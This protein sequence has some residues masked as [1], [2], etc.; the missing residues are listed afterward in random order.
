M[1][2]GVYYGTAGVVCCGSVMEYRLLGT[3]IDGVG[4]ESPFT[5]MIDST[6]RTAGQANS[7][8]LRRFTIHVVL[9]TFVGASVYLLFRTRSLLVFHWVEAI[10]LQ[11]HL[12]V[13]RDAVSDVQ[14]PQWLL[15]SLPDG[16]WVYATTSWMVL[17]WREPRSWLWLSTGVLLA[18]GAEAGQA[19]GC[20]PGTYQHLDMLFYGGA[21]LLALLKP[22][23]ANETALSLFRGTSC[24]DCPRVR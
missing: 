1:R 3:S 21:F 23:W 14:L 5:A 2:T 15:Y 24:D 4:T 6:H 13:L 19:V 20:I 12:T 9:P 16:L 17:I 11:G 7:G 10:G 22:R 8:T 18:V